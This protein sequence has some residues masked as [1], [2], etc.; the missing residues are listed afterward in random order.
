MS[1]YYLLF[2]AYGYEAVPIRDYDRF[3][4]YVKNE[5]LSKTLRLISMINVRYIISEEEILEKGLKLAYL[6]KNDNRIIRIY[7]N[8]HVLP[9]AY[10][11]HR[12]IS[13]KD[14]K[15]VFKALTSPS[16]NP[17]KEIILE[18]EIKCKIQNAKSKMQNVKITNY[19]P[20]KITIKIYSPVDCILFLSDA[21]YPGWK[22]YIDGK[23][24][25]IYRA[26]YIFRAIKFPAGTHKVEF[27]YFPTSFKAGLLGSML[28][29]ILLVIHQILYNR[30]SEGF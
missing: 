7:E 11:V 10:L 26:N 19:L 13:V 3:I 1:L 5:R 20:N 27:V 18:E 12:V 9:R 30:L 8:P 14:R 28:T 6:I 22:A 25:K 23:E 16:F 15:N 17:A 4:Y 2:D 21:Y 29:L 24:T